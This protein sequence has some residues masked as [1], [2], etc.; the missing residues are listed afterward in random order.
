MSVSSCS[1][2]KGLPDIRSSQ[3]ALALGRVFSSLLVLHDDARLLSKRIIKSFPSN[4]LLSVLWFYLYCLLILKMASFQYQC[5]LNQ[6]L[7]KTAE[8]STCS[9][10]VSSAPIRFLLLQSGFFCSNPVSSAPIRASCSLRCR[11]STQ[12]LISGIC[13]TTVSK[14][15][16][17]GL[18]LQREKKKTLN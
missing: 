8:E 15:C 2:Q 7:V 12:T 16:L 18:F 4:W 6:L 17:S 11:A 1:L 5:T 3:I 10:P 14:S 9:N 13:A